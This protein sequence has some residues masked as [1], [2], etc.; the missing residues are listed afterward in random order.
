MPSLL[1]R[2]FVAGSACPRG[3][4]DPAVI[5]E[6]ERRISRAHEGNAYG[7]YHVPCIFV[8]SSAEGLMSLPPGG[9]GTA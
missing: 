6:R 1:G 3:C 5:L 8:P 9:R 4:F 2:C 7:A